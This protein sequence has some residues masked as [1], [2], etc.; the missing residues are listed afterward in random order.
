MKT[1]LEGVSNRLMRGDVLLHEQTSINWILLQSSV[2][3]R[4]ECAGILVAE[5]KIIMTQIVNVVY[6][7]PSVVQWHCSGS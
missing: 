3:N 5:I 4:K 1:F 7:L 6:P 2:T